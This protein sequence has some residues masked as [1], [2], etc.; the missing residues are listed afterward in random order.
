MRIKL[1][2][3]LNAKEISAA[4]HGLTSDISDATYFTHITTDSREACAGDIFIALRGLNFDGESFVSE[5]RSKGAIPVTIQNI[6]GAITVNDT[7]AALLS[8][9]EYY[10]SLLKKLKHT[11]CSSYSTLMAGSGCIASLHF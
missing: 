5:A 2:I 3:R 8:L 6:S 9:A 11:N 7:Q 1:G 4:V 10:K